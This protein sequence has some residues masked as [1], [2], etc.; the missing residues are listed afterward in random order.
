MRVQQKAQ[1]QGFTLIELMIVIAIIAILAGIGIPSYQNYMAKARFA[2]VIS[3]AAL[4]Q[5]QVVECFQTTDRDATVCATQAESI[6][7]GAF[8][9]AIISTIKA[10]GDNANNKVTITTTT[11]T[12]AFNGVTHTMVGI[13]TAAG[14]VLWNLDDA[15]STCVNAALC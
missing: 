4:P 2:E 6:V 12:A 3:T 7:S 11:T 8:N 9:T 10:V 14:L 5:D 1:Q 15:N 13:K